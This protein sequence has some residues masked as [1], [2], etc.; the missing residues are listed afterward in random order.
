MTP[1]LKRLLHSIPFLIISG[2]MLYSW[3]EFV[4]GKYIS[5]WR[6]YLALILIAVN[7]VL[8][9]V[10]FRETVI[11][12]GVLALFVL[13]WGAEYRFYHRMVFGFPGSK[14]K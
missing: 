2:I 9:F 12:T 13:Y 8:Y 11:L 5:M 3:I 10:R 14:R 7:A 1:K 4:S 6:H